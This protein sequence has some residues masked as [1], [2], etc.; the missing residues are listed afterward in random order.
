MQQKINQSILHIILI[1]TLLW[2]SI[3]VMAKNINCQHLSAE[4]AFLQIYPQTSINKT[5]VNH[6]ID[7]NT[8]S[9]A[10]L[11]Q[12]NGISSKKAQAIILY[13]EMIAPFEQIDDLAKVAGIGKATVEKNRHLITVNK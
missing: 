13:R 7:L 8:A 10:Q 4:Q 11:V 5:N 2:L 9:E 3:D 12:L 1:I 6:L